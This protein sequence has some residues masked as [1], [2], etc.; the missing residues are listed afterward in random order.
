MAGITAAIVGAYVGGDAAVAGFVAVPVAFIV[1]LVW[2]FL[3]SIRLRNLWFLF[4]DHYDDSAVNGDAVSAELDRI[5]RET[6]TKEFLKYIGSTVGVDT[7]AGLVAM[8]AKAG[9]AASG[10]SRVLDRTVA[11]QGIK[12]YGQ[13]VAA[14]AQAYAKI[15]AAY[16]FYKTARA[17]LGL[18]Q[19]INEKVYALARE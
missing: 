15:V 19:K 1:F 11:G 5:N 2:C 7:L 18:G 8:V 13:A 12:M 17:R 16:V 9:A 4:L 14:Q 6:K 10:A 3:V